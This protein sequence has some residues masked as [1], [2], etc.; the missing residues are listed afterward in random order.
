MVKIEITP[1]RYF[2]NCNILFQERGTS[3]EPPPRANFSATANQVGLDDLV[4]DC[5][6]PLKKYILHRVNT[7]RG[8]Y[9]RGVKL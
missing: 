8:S 5:F 1:D 6:I 9:N 3:T 2:V 7:C 4:V